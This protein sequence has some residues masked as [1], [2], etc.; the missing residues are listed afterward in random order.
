MQEWHNNRPEKNEQLASCLPGNFEF[1]GNFSE[2][3]NG[4]TNG[5]K[6]GS[7]NGMQINDYIISFKLKQNL[8]IS[9]KFIN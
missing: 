6:N 3:K 1:G 8:L 2:N 7:R 4:S 5:N 9:F